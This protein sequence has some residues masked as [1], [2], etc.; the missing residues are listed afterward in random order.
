MN[1]LDIDNV[2][3]VFS[4]LKQINCSESVFAQELA[5]EL[6]CKKTELMAF[7]LDNEPL[8]ITENDKKGL[9]IKN[10]YKNVES[11]PWK[12][13]YLT[14]KIAEND[15]TLY[16]KQWNYYGQFGNYYVEEDEMRDPNA[17]YNRRYDLWRNTK[18][19]MERFKESKHYYEG[20]GP[21]GMFSGSILPYS[22]KSEHMLDLIAE[23]WR[24]DG[25]VP[26]MIKNMQGGNAK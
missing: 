4:L 6:G 17:S 5:K 9:K 3:K 8:F 18:E 16:I 15:K 14:K 12:K 11:N 2:I 1:K 7:I 23:G 13:E 10:V 25:E 19:K 21:N 22:L 26:Q 24:L 20:Y